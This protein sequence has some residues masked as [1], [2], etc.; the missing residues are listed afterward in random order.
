MP[1]VVWWVIL[2]TVTDP[3]LV[4]YQLEVIRGAIPTFQMTI[5]TQLL[6]LF[7]RM[8]CDIAAKRLPKRGSRVNPR[9]VK[10]KM[11]NFKLKRPE[12][13]PSRPLDQPFQASLA[14]I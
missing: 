5:R 6:Q 1:A 11:S 3:R 12:H 13:R 7:A 4:G 14:R 9:V 10:R 8:L 2:S